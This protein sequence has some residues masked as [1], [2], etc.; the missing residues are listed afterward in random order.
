MEA[1]GKLNWSTFLLLIL[2]SFYHLENI[3][4]NDT[5]IDDWWIGKC[6]KGVVLF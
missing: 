1:D 3:A 4:W 2:Q 6:L 5:I